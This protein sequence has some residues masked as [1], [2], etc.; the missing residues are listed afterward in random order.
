MG[1]E[2]DWER[3]A[4]KLDA[5]N[6]ASYIEF[7]QHHTSCTLHKGNVRTSE[8]HPI[9]WATKEAHGSYPAGADAHSGDRITGTGP[10]W[11]TWNYLVPLTSQAWYKYGGG[12]GRVGEH[13]NTTGPDAPPHQTV[14]TFKTPFCKS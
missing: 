6:R 11:K 9:V 7:F 4:I 5:S 14:P 8:L 1:H 3:I 10:A 2:G 12:W 13:T